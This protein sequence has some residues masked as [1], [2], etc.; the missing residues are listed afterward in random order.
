MW[1]ILAVFGLALAV[2]GLWCAWTATRLDRLHLQC[3]SARAGLAEA[4]MRR[5]AAATD[6][7]LSG[8][9]DPASSLALV[10]AAS[11]AREPTSDDWQAQSDFSAVLRVVRASSAEATE[12]G[13]ELER[14][15]REVSMSRR[16]HNDLVVRTQG[17]HQRRRV[18]WFRL[19]GH[20][21]SPRTVEFDSIDE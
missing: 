12:A 6:L 14:A 18:R 4:L 16:I 3:Q 13:G 5:S 19:A 17:L 11:A 15:C 21:D 8:R 1:L 7:A 2:I 20:A 9:L 10:D